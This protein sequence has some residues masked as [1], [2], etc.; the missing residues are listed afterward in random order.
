MQIFPGSE[1]LW[2]GL[3]F[4]NMLTNPNPVTNLLIESEFFEILTESNEIYIP[5]FAFCYCGINIC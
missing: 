5:P 1:L 3:G 4:D 2:V